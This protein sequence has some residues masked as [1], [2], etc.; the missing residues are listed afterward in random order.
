MVRGLGLLAVKHL[1]RQSDGEDGRWG[2]SQLCP[3]LPAEDMTCITSQIVTIP[4][5]P[6]NCVPKGKAEVPWLD[7]PIALNLRLGTVSLFHP[8]R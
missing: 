6:H 1:A 5:P 3:S 4:I 2:Q 7:L 8:C